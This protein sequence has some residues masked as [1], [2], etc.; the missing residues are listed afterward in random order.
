MAVTTK[1][2]TP[3]QKRKT[4]PAYDTS[5]W[6]AW[7][8]LLVGA[9]LHVVHLPGGIIWWADRQGQHGRACAVDPV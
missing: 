3:A 4:A 9:A 8:G 7:G 1:K 2:R 5:P 6:I